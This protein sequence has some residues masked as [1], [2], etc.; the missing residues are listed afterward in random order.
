MAERLQLLLQ[1]CSN[2]DTIGDPKN[3]AECISEFHITMQLHESVRYPPSPN[4]RPK[5]KKKKC[6]TQ[7]DQNA[8]GGY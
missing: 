6:W 2:L 4:L 1:K 5:K 8:L 3:P 7:K